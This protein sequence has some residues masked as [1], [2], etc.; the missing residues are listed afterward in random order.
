M[1]GAE[2]GPV[3]AYGGLAIVPVDRLT[4]RDLAERTARQL[5]YAWEAEPG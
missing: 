3:H 5:D 1:I 4:D 2:T